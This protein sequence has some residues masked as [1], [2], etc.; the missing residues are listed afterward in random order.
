[1]QKL[2][3]REA[4]IHQVANRR[5]DRVLRAHG[6]DLGAQA[7]CDLVAA[8][9]SAE[10]TR[11]TSRLL[12]VANDQQVEAVLVA[13][14]SG[15]VGALINDTR[16]TGLA[17][18]E[19]WSIGLEALVKAIRA[20]A[21]CD[22]GDFHIIRSTSRDFV[23]A[24]QQHRDRRKQRTE[25]EQME[26]NRILVERSAS[27]HDE[28]TSAAIAELVEWVATQ[29]EA[30]LAVARMVVATRVGGYP[31]GPKGRSTERVRNCR[32]R[33]AVEA[34]MRTYVSPADGLAVNVLA[35]VPRV[36]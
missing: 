5:T 7:V 15:Y 17:Q 28:L 10:R 22:G 18:A 24:I 23:R 29:F 2:V 32:E 27:F 11:L 25:F 33:K 20:A 21:R 13:A 30:D 26:R 34:K 8:G 3:S 19:M 9:T 14:F 4:I 35:R 31:L 12:D 6:I 36:A 1:M 16:N